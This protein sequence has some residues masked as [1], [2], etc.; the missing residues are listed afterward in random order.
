M[1]PIDAL[2][3]LLQRC[4]AGDGG[5]F[6]DLYRRAAPT[7]FSAILRLVKRRDL[8]E[9][10]LQEAFVKIWQHAG[11]YEP[12]RGKALAWMTGIVRHR[13]LDWLRRSNPD[14][15]LETIPDRE[16]WVDPASELRDEALQW[17]EARALWN[18]L[19]QLPSDTRRAI[20]LT[21]FEGHTHEALSRLMEVPLG[22]VK[23]WIRR[24]LPQLRRCL[25]T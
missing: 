17:H 5:A 22:T 15:P 6:A 7:L 9:E 1:E 19:E 12:E 20:L 3:E 11:D 16:A 2:G 18:C 21:Y 25:E 8:G 10:I 23:S 14:V 13:S 4:A 24:A